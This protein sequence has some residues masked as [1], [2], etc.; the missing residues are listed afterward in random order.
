MLREQQEKQQ[1]DGFGH[2]GATGVGETFA[3]HVKSCGRFRFY[4]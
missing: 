3:A 1:P 4:L 2:T